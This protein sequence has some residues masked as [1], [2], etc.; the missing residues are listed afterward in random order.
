MSKNLLVQ[1]HHDMAPIVMISYNRP[2]L[3]RLTMKNVSL[4]NGAAN[5]EIFMFIDGPRNEN[6]KSKQDEIHSIVMSYQKKLPGLA[7]IRRDVNYGCRG[8]IVDAISTTVSKYGKVI[9]IEDDVLISRT[10]LEYMDEALAFYEDDKSIWSIN[11][12][13]SPNLRIPRDYPYDVY[14]DPV[15]MCWGWGTW[16]DRWKQV[17]FDMKDWASSRTDPELIARLN[18]AGRQLLRMI[19]LQAAGVL[20]TWDVQ[21]A[22]HVAKNGLMSIEPRF[23][24]SKNIG[25][26]ARVG[27]EHNSTQMPSIARQPYYNFRPKLV[28]DLVH[29][30]RIFQQFE[31]IGTPKNLMWRIVRKLK[32]GFAYLKPENLEPKEV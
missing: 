13:Q 30:P 8:N 3:V 16:A 14:L 7:I 26:S 22:Y 2:E 10:F 20:K 18:R 17:D 19:E 25:F 9:V 29:D 6:D 15:N 4:A 5:H 32:R 21:C 12:Y 23:Q 11:A 28:H 1:E 24:L 27:G 31:W